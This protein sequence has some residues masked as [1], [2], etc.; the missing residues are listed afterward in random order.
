VVEGLRHVGS[1]VIRLGDRD[2]GREKFR[3]AASLGRFLGRLILI[4]L[5]GGG[6]FLLSNPPFPIL[7]FSFLLLRQ[8]VISRQNRFSRNRF[9]FN[10]WC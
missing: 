2:G 5:L 1:N 7:L 9:Q 10:V 8:L 4:P 6:V 3:L